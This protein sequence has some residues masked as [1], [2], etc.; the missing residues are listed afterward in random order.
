MAPERRSKH[1]VNCDGFALYS[2][3]VFLAA[4]TEVS[5]VRLR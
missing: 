5:A 1:D 3:R 2:E 4:L